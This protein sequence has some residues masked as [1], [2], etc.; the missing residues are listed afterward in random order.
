[1]EPV[2]LNEWDIA[3]GP[4][5]Y[6][7]LADEDYQYGPDSRKSCYYGADY[8]IRTRLTTTRYA[9]IA[10]ILD[11]TVVRAQSDWSDDLTAGST[12]WSW[13]DGNATYRKSVTCEG[14]WQSKPYNYGTCLSGLDPATG[15]PYTKKI[16]F[17]D[18]EIPYTHSTQ[19]GDFFLFRQPT[20]QCIRENSDPSGFNDCTSMLKTDEWIYSATYPTM[21][22]DHHI[23]RS[24][25]EVVTDHF[26]YDNHGLLTTRTLADDTS[27]YQLN[28]S[29]AHGR[30]VNMAFNGVTYYL[31]DRGEDPDV[32]IDPVTGLVLW[33]KDSAGIKTCF[34]YDLLGRL[35]HIYPDVA[36]QNCDSTVPSFN[37]EA[38]TKIVYDSPN[39]TFVGQFHPDTP[40]EL[41]STDHYFDQFGRVVVTAKTVPIDKRVIKV[42][43]YT[44]SGLLYH[45][46]EW[47][48]GIVPRVD[49][50]STYPYLQ[51][52]V[53]PTNPDAIGDSVYMEYPGTFYTAFD[54]NG[55]FTK[56]ILPDG[57]WSTIDYDGIKKK[58]V[59]VYH[60]INHTLQN[61]TTYSYDVFGRLIG[62]LDG[63]D[64]ETRYTYNELDQLIVV[65]Q[66]AG[67]CDGTSDQQLR[68]F[69][70][71]FTGNIV[72]ETH[73]ELDQPLTYLDYD[74]MGNLL[75][76]LDALG[77]DWS[78]VYDEAGR[79]KEV[80]LDSSTNNTN[81]LFQQF[82]YDGDFPDSITTCVDDDTDTKH[83][84][85]CGKL[86]QALQ[87][88]V[89]PTDSQGHDKMDLQ[90]RYIYSG[91][92]GRLSRHVFDSNF[93]I[94]KYFTWDK[95]HKNRKTGQFEEIG[96]NS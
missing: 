89:P 18:H 79:L 39:H 2:P 41:T 57:T 75:H 28:Y 10:G 27:S 5:G 44:P 58:T 61:S 22:S 36:V 66:C 81:K 24:P 38:Y 23:Y 73:P 11:T 30:L 85:S 78:Y 92:G 15:A 67:L 76:K 31:L 34:K 87:K 13:V 48:S 26:E 60:P 21:L 56:T 14:Q 47:F 45:E 63:L 20:E 16:S 71:D 91:I 25:S 49:E 8:N 86:I 90:H 72:Q 3:N 4:R 42:S 37:R 59:N 43:S 54:Y 62:I 65:K 29:F 9:N 68:S 17:S 46:S 64:N 88:P 95:V 93:F 50:L 83:G 69:T 12:P 7:Y 40:V 74:A 52:E 51:T 82:F 35:T 80:Y 77:Q 6:W 84:R 70:Y 55:R 96:P 19:G 1:M 32:G 33:E 94:G 53:S